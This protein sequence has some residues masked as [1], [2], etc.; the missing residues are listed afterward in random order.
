MVSDCVYILGE[1][2]RGKERGVVTR[3]R[4]KEGMGG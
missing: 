1:A 4:K 2:V 3:E